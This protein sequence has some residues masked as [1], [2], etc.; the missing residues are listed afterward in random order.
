MLTALQ[1]LQEP[2]GKDG[3]DGAPGE[4]GVSP[5]VEITA[6]D[7]GNRVSITD[8]EGSSSFDVMNG[9]DGAP[10]TPGAD[11]ADGH[12]PIKGVDYWT[13]EDKAEM[14]AD[15]IAALPVYNGEV[16]SDV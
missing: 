15:T 2:P 5:T 10:G 4:D 8:A 9:T 1:A 7:G 16:V 6:I 11:G 13:E 14:V 3:K 12:T